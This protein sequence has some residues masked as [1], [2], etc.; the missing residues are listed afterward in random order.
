M[1][2]EYLITFEA[3]DMLCVD[4]ERFKHLLM[5]HPSITF[6]SKNS[7]IFKGYDYYYLLAFGI[8]P[9]GS[10]YYD[11]TIDCPDDGNEVVYADLLKEIR[12]ICGKIN[13]R[14]T[15][16]L[17]DGIGEKYCQLSY[18]IVYKTENL[19]RKLISKFM[20]IGMGLNWADSSIPHEV[21]DSIH[22][23]GK[24]DKSNIIY[25]VD[26]IQ[27]SK[28]LFTSYKK[29][30][31]NIFFESL[32]GKGDNESLT[33]GELKQ[34]VP[35][36]NWEKYFSQKVK[37]ESDYLKSRWDRLY[38]IRCTVAHCRALSFVEYSELVKVSGEVCEK[39]QAALDSIND[40]H[41][42]PDDREELA[43]N[44]SGATNQCVAE[45]ISQYNRM[46]S[47]LQ[48]VCS[49]VSTSD[50]LYNKVES[51]SLNIRMQAKYLYGNKGIIDAEASKTIE[52]AQIFRNKIVHGFGVIDVKD[53]EIMEMIEK[54]YKVLNVI[55]KRD[56]DEYV[57]F[58]STDLKKRAPDSLVSN[59][60]T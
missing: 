29:N 49:L 42:S 45:F 13:G 37:C 38:V 11:L 21:T 47:T 59:P 16:V 4:V 31:S 36:T 40:I 8:L 60:I 26:F 18:P 55:C 56:P 44:I 23:R 46:A 51:N 6:G 54:V 15:V 41:I 43:E 50:D 22:S 28:Y 35:F 48:I 30:D 17:L 19:M 58:K 53:S 27:L 24:A 14:G 39:L 2:T 9:D 1:K 57:S 3:G 52:D 20:V 34:Y 5:A 12:R 10:L 7:I 32:K 33:V 25:E